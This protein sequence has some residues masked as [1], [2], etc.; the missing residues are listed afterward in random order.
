MLI[1]LPKIAVKKKN[2]RI[3]WKHKMLG[4]RGVLKRCILRLYVAGW[5]SI[6]ITQ[7]LIDSLKLREA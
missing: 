3:L 7:S 5:L 4:V 2:V 6:P 1:P